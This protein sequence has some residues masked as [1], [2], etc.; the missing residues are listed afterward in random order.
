MHLLIPFSAF[1]KA[2]AQIMSLFFHV[3]DG[4]KT[5]ARFYL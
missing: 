5:L 1:G 2:N 3:T 4:Y